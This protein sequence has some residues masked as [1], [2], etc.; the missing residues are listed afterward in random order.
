LL[1]LISCE[2]NEE[3]YSVNEITVN[4][5][6]KDW[7]KATSLRT[8]PCL[9]AVM[10]IILMLSGCAS[11]SSLMVV[12]MTK[13]EFLQKTSF[14]EVNISKIYFDPTSRIEI[15]APDPLY[16]SPNNSG[17]ITVVENVSAEFDPL[18][19][20][21][22]QMPKATCQQKGDG[23]IRSWYTESQIEELAI[24]GDEEATLLLSVLTLRQ[25]EFE[26]DITKIMNEG[27]EWV[28][29]SSIIKGGQKESYNPII[30]PIDRK[31][32]IKIY[33]DYQENLRFTHQREL[34][35]MML[36]TFVNSP[37][38]VCDRDS[39]GSPL[40]RHKSEENTTSYSN[41]KKERTRK[42]QPKSSLSSNNFFEDLIEQAL[43]LYV[44]KALGIKSPSYGPSKD[45]LREIEEASRRGMR[46]ALKKQKRMDNIYKNIKTPPPI[47]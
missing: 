10:L 26:K 2:A 24:S 21:C 15:F 46:K 6:S 42:T 40:C 17:L 5:L 3:Q 47:R 1:A 12:G 22:D 34:A 27:L 33:K 9:C 36:Y 32:A 39:N 29:D 4:T 38:Y 19:R 41:I 45:D 43:D 31:K 28:W 18:Y 14:W 20:Y 30:K 37:M 44:Q 16:W 7:N 35:Q 13:E 23:R 11:Q 25:E 8:N